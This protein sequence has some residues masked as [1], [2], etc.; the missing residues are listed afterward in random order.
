MLNNPFRRFP[1]RAVATG[2][3]DN[4]VTLFDVYSYDGGGG[5]GPPHFAMVPLLPPT[6]GA[7]TDRAA[8]AAAPEALPPHQVM[9][10]TFPVTSYFSGKNFNYGILSIF[11][12]T[13]V[14]SK[15]PYSAASCTTWY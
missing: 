1:T 9:E 14:L 7:R 5:F 4:I 13:K 3:H 2:A 15:P 6:Q 8:R 10:L 12:D 11:G